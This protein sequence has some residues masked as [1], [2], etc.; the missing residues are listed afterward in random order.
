[1]ISDMAKF[2]QASLKEDLKKQEVVL[3]KTP[4]QNKIV[5]KPQTIWKENIHLINNS[6]NV[7]ILIND[8]KMENWLGEAFC[9]LSCLQ[10]NSQ[11]KF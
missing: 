1:M 6:K 4:L 8:F 7:L 9:I 3:A 11:R 10:D 5:K 2:L